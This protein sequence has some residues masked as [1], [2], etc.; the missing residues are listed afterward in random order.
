MDEGNNMLRGEYPDRYWVECPDCEG[1]G[2]IPYDYFTEDEDGNLS[3]R[4]ET[5][6]GIGE[7][8]E[9]R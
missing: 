2:I 6:D 7:V 8:E 9:E 3:K 1:A 5:C 4:C